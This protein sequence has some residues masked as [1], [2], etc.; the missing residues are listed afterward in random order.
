MNIKVGKIE[1]GHGV[2]GK[3]VG[4]LIAAFLAVALVG[5][6]APKSGELIFETLL[7]PL[8][9]R[10]VGHSAAR[11]AIE[12]PD[13]ITPATFAQRWLAFSHARLSPKWPRSV[14]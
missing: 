11:I 9:A 4:R 3:G 2:G 13:S 7:K 8:F 5:G 12:A 1:I 14:P 6:I 10:D